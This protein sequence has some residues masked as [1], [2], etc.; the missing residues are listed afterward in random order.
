VFHANYPF[1]LVEPCVSTQDP[2]ATE[3]CFADEIF[4]PAGCGTIRFEY[5]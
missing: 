3:N 5:Q 2:K 1:A 4:H